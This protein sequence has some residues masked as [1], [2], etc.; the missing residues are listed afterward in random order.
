MRGR[1]RQ[2]T[3]SYISVRSKSGLCNT[4]RNDFTT[5]TLTSKRIHLNLPVL[6]IRSKKAI[7]IKRK[8]FWN[9][10]TRFVTITTIFHMMPRLALTRINLFESNNVTPFGICTNCPFQKNTTTIPLVFL[11]EQI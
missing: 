5:H 11:V 1:P 8:C 7:I 10:T 4:G 9:I 3:G 6:F 2:T